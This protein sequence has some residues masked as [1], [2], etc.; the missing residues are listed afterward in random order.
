MA[1]DRSGAT[2]P[3][4]LDISKSFDRTWHADLLH[5][6]K[7]YKMS[8]QMFG[9]ISSFLSNRPLWVVL[10]GKSSQECPVNAELLKG[11]FLV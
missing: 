4:A 3:V 8:D 7:S 5:K 9:F 11:P 1:F 2:R 10:D 6:L